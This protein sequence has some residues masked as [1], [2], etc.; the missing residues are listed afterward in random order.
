MVKR[1]QR[2]Q[3]RTSVNTVAVWQRH[4][5]RPEGN[6]KGNCN[7][8][9]AKNPVSDPHCVISWHL[10]RFTRDV[11]SGKGRES[12]RRNERTDLRT[13]LRSPR[14]TW[15]SRFEDTRGGCVGTPAQAGRAQQ[16]LARG[17][18]GGALSPP[19]QLQGRAA[20]TAPTFGFPSGSRGVDTTPTIPG[21]CSSN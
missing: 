10:G 12:G 14:P 9:G 2:S 1:Q 17:G 7:R 4:K 16:P 19:A 3:Q 13:L 18:L 20:P 11:M 6:K 5:V 8:C 15:T 21:G